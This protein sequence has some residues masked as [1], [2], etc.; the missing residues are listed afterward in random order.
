M[1]PAS[2]TATIGGTAVEAVPFL[3]RTPRSPSQ[4]PASENGGP[5]GHSADPDLRTSSNPAPSRTA[6]AAAVRPGPG[7]ADKRTSR[8]SAKRSPERRSRFGALHRRLR[9]LRVV[10]V[11]SSGNPPILSGALLLCLDPRAPGWGPSPSCFI[12]RDALGS[13]THTPG[14]S[15]HGGWEGVGSRRQCRT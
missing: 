5:A 8:R 12:R 9:G 4:V 1:H 15:W 7:S 13:S 2:I 10:I 11:A 6:W 14:P 3:R